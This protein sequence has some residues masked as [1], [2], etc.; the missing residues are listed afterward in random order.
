MVSHTVPYELHFYPQGF[1]VMITSNVIYNVKGI[2]PSF[3]V[4]QT[5]EL[6]RIIHRLENQGYSTTR[7]SVWQADMLF[8]HMH[9]STYKLAKFKLV[10]YFFTIVTLA[11]D[12]NWTK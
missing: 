7:E 9:C 4:S 10:A 1:V 8:W 5:I 3:C 11:N 6:R 12:D 2:S